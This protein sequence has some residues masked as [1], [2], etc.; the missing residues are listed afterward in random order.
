METSEN[1]QPEIV[2]AELEEK[3][4]EVKMISEFLRG[5]GKERSNIIVGTLNIFTAP[6][7]AIAEPLANR[8][9]KRYQGRY[10]FARTLFVFDLFLLA[11]AVALAVT[12]LSLVL[13]SRVP[14]APRI[15]VE[16]APAALKIGEAAS[17]NFRITNATS[18]RVEAAAVEIKLPKQFVVISAPEDFPKSSTVALGD[19]PPGAIR[20]FGLT[21]LVLPSASSTVAEVEN[22]FTVLTGHSGKIEIKTA[23]RT[24]V[25]FKDSVLDA[26]LEIPPT[27]NVGETA[28]LP[29]VVKNQGAV[30]LGP[31][32]VEVC[33]GGNVKITASV[34]GCFTENLSLLGPGGS[35]STTI[36]VVPEGEGAKAR[37]RLRVYLEN[38][39]GMALLFE[40]GFEMET[41]A[42][43]A[44][45]EVSSATGLGRFAVR[46]RLA[47]FEP[48]YGLSALR[49]VLSLE[50]GAEKII[51]EAGAGALRDFGEG[52]EVLLSPA[53]PGSSPGAVS[54]EAVFLNPRGQSAV[55][56]SASVALPRA[57]EATLLAAARYFSV[58]GEQ[59]GRGPLPP[60]AGEAT[61]YWIFWNLAPVKT[62]LTSVAI[63][64]RLPPG[65]RWLERASLAAPASGKI[66]YDAG[67]REITLEASGLDL[68]AAAAGVNAAFAISFTPS[69]KDV[70]VEPTII[71]EAA[72]VLVTTDGLKSAS[73]AAALTTA[74]VGDDRA[75]GRGV[76]VK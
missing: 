15:A 28:T 23:V 24:P 66:S 62:A 22:I 57:P 16:V 29:L 18:E 54:A 55:V 72:A 34:N 52:K 36:K 12:S 17:L 10:R 26:N 14:A 1:N 20:N 19:L 60:A 5:P 50:N 58:E 32:R 53:D 31:L 27:S 44:A 47:R 30:A 13:S 59:L 42:G 8:F 3:I 49:L 67:R 64:A 63:R 11:A 43:P 65:S 38:E 33:P 56:R 73:T 9:E 61:E 75:G 40:R 45:I 7:K 76:V 41:V 39:R 69:A 6:A 25:S 35:T 70:G 46:T 71:N 21:V 37:L 4:P 68:A 74:L 2:K 48:G 51:A